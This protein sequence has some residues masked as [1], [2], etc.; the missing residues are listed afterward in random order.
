MRREPQS[1]ETTVR[2]QAWVLLAIGLLGLT[3]PVRVRA[4][5]PPDPLSWEQ[6]L[7]SETSEGLADEAEGGRRVERGLCLLS[8][9]V[10][11]REVS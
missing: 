11:V 1:G 9:G 7:L 4:E 2:L 8:S 5:E 6:R 3:M 10:D